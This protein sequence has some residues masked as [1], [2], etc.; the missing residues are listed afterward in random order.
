MSGAMPLRR[1]VEQQRRR[2][3]Q[4]LGGLGQRGRGLRRVAAREREE[5]LAEVGGAVLIDAGDKRERHREIRRRVAA[6]AQQPSRRLEV[7][8]VQRNPSGGVARVGILSGIVQRAAGASH[9]A[10]AHPAECDGTRE[11]GARGGREPVVVRDHQ[12]FRR[13]GTTERGQCA[14]VHGQQRA[15]GASRVHASERQRCERERG[16]R[17]AAVDRRDRRTQCDVWR[18]TP[19]QHGSERVPCMRP[20]FLRFRALGEVEPRSRADAVRRKVA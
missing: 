10:H 5:S 6:R 12:P 13:R 17:I 9:V 16:A 19:A 18:L 20:P 3:W 7:A 8:G 14:H 11:R 15:R 2:I 4:M 1:S